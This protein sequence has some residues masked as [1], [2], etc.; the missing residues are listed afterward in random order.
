MRKISKLISILM[1]ATVLPGVLL[2]F[3]GPPST[4]HNANS[5]WIEPVQLAFN[6][7]TTNVGFT[8]NVTVYA[9]IT[10][11]PG[12]HGIGGWQFKLLYNTSQLNATERTW[13]ANLTA[14]K[15]DI[16]WDIPTTRPAPVFDHA[17]GSVLAGEVWAGNPTTGPFAYT[18]RMG[19]LAIVEFQIIAAPPNGGNLTSLLD[20]ST[21]FTTEDTYILDYDSLDDIGETVYN[22]NF[23][24]SSSQVTPPPV[25][26]PFLAVDP[27]SGTYGASVNVTG[28]H[29]NENIYIKSLS[30]AWY[31]VNASLKLHY[32]HM[33]NILAVRSVTFNTTA[34]NVAATFDNTTYGALG[35]YVETDAVSPPLNGDALVATLKFEIIYQGVSPESNTVPLTFSDVALSNSTTSIPTDPPVT[36]SIT[37]LGLAPP[38][39]MGATLYIDPS[40]I[41][42]PTLVPSTTFYV[43]IVVTNVTD[44]KACELNLTYDSGVLS[45]IGVV[46]QRVQGQIPRVDII[47][48]DTG[49]IWVKLNYSSPFSTSTPIPLVSILFHVEALGATLLHLHDTQL[50][51]HSGN[52]ITHQE[53]DGFFMSIIRH[54]VVT[55]VVPSRS[56]ALA[57]WPVDINVTVKNLGNVSETFNVNATY[58]S[59]LIGTAAVVNLPPN[60]ETTITIP[61]NTSGVPEGNYTMT[62]AVSAVPFE[63][64]MTNKVYVDGIVQILTTIHD[65]A[66]TDVSPARNWVYEGNLI[67][68]NV[69]VKNV[70]TV[71]ES[72]NVTAQCDSILVGTAPVVGLAPDA[73]LTLTLVWNTTFVTPCHNYT[74][75]GQASIVPFEFNTTNNIYTDGTIT[76][77]IV[78]DVNGDGKVDI[79]DILVV[80]KAF[81]S[82]PGD[83]R[84]NPYADINND[85]TVNIKDILLVAKNFGKTCSP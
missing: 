7:A 67:N 18:P 26:P 11:V 31:I 76:V 34:W 46:V 43:N 84:W 51:D 15:S 24:Y 41:T 60:N 62:G 38:V 71:T 63:F 37:V 54:V 57:G 59:N 52:P 77:R 1:I 9:N 23:E 58:D 64:N 66:I 12:A 13:Y 5:M 49:F 50:L 16:F 33:P 40:N 79:Q 70:G 72:F 68:I 17:E 35:I 36:G 22:A 21:G 27:A 61:W 4:P 10:S 8:F 44:L 65:V 82:S 45:G 75:S 19:G 2:V 25:P 39:P 53:V 32:D 20:I 78:G 48:S 83:P 55:N 6:T 3:A 47:L 30:A 14:G 85:N 69:T 74:V 81:G 56:W 80:A 73:E 29:F 28:L 42:D